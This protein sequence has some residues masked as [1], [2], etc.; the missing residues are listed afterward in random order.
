MRRNCEECGRNYDD[1]FCSTMCPHRGMG[2]CAVC[3]CTICVCTKET[4]GR[5]WERSSN[6]AQQRVQTSDAGR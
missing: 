5:N 6:F 3:D 2:F 4:A 1:E